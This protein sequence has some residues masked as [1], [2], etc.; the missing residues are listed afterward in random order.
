MNDIQRLCV[1]QALYKAIAG[2]VKTRTPGNLRSVL[3]AELVR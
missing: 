1:A 3:D 2:A